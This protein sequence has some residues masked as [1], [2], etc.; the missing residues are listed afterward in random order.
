MKP[1]L[2]L[3]LLLANFIQQPSGPTCILSPCF[4]Y[5]PKPAPKEHDCLNLR[6]HHQEHFVGDKWVYTLY[7]V[8]EEFAGQEEYGQLPYCTDAEVKKVLAGELKLNAA[9]ERKAK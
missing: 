1:A 5:T 6:T 8:K 2:Y 3:A 7:L 9:P 4:F